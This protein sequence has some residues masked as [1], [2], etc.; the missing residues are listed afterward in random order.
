MAEDPASPLGS[1]APGLPSQATQLFPVTTPVKLVNGSFEQDGKGFFPIGF[2]F[3]DGE[4]ELRQAAAI[5]CNAI[6]LEFAWNR[7][8]KIFSE[9]KYHD[10]FDAVQRAGDAGLVVFPLLG[11]HYVPAWFDREHPRAENQPLGSDGKPTGSW[12]PYSLNDPLYREAL[13]PFWQG[14][15]ARISTMPCVAALNLW[16]EPSYGGTWNKG[17]QF[18][19]YSVHGLTAFRNSLKGRYGT[20]DELNKAYGNAFNTWDDV[21][22]PK[23]IDEGHPRAW[24]EWMEFGQE[25]FADFFQR[26][27]EAIREVAP[28]LLLANKKQIN[29]WDES[30]ASSGTNWEKL[31]GS[32][33]LFG[34]N[35]YSGS[36]NWSRNL[37]AAACSY[38]NGKPVVIFE[39]NIMPPEKTARTPDLVR[40]QLWAPVVGGAR[41]MFIFAM[42]ANTEHGF[43]NDNAI[44]AEARQAYVQ[45]IQNIRTHQ[46]ALSRPP[47][48]GKIGIVYS[49]TAAL[50][51]PTSSMPRYVNGA[52]ELFR[53]SHFQ[54]EIIPQ[55]LC[56]AKY[57]GRFDLVVL[58]TGTIL[59]DQQ[60]SGLQKYSEGGGRILAF[61]NAL[62]TNEYLE[63]KDAPAFL[64][65]GSRQVAVGERLQQKIGKVE[66][67]L[68]PYVDAEIPV[69]GAELVVSLQNERQEKMMPGMKLQTKQK[70]R[71]LAYN[72]DSYPVILETAPSQTVYCA[73]ESTAS[74]GLR[75]LIEGITREVFH[76]KQEVRI[77]KSSDGTVDPAILTGLREEKVHDGKRYL[78][79]LNSAYRPKKIVLEA[80]GE[81][82]V[83]RELLHSKDAA[84][85]SS[86]QMEPR[87]MYLF[88]LVKRK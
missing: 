70:G 82:E 67:E 86:V 57:L 3:G 33:D 21:V 73:F 10:R 45:F 40:C 55:E 43:L 35:L 39:I 76:L 29:P 27:R 8:E 28:N 7:A 80:N 72:S 71:V 56:T 42:I 84:I 11:C 77:V 88:E 9:E 20:I 17:R 18:A 59:K 60:L 37:L 19:D 61:A 58:P 30:A 1:L 68:T 13:R 47:V 16:N 78:L 51:Q 81:W 62:D 48:I 22:P 23:S 2:V 65:I 74:D 69:T 83:S 53:N 64:G 15:A 31:G 87:E 5:G 6:H 54:T 41:G 38:A 79:A 49:T 36:I 63:K 85:T 52:A 24:L 50:M 26:E 66:N 34:I 25:R 46:D 75:A 4:K 14:I 44:T 32:E 12:T